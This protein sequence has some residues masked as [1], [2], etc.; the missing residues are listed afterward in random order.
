M[1]LIGTPTGVYKVGTIRRNP[2]GEQWSQE[3]IKNMAG[4]PQQFEPGV[5]MRRI[6][7]V[8]KKK[9]DVETT[10]PPVVFQPPPI[11]HQYLAT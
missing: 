5:G 4:S 2:D 11:N 6:T 7:I 8:A 3:M 1:S 9:L 10:G